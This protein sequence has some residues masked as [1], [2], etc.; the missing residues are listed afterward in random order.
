MKNEKIR[1]LALN[2]DLEAGSDGFYHLVP[3]GEFP[4]KTTAGKKVMQICDAQAVNRM[5][6]TFKPKALIDFEHRSYNKDGDT[7]AAGWIVEVAARPDGLWGKI[8]WSDLGQAA[9]ANKRYRGHSPVLDLDLLEGN[10]G[11]PSAIVGSGLT[12][13][14]VMRDALQPLLNKDSTGTT[15]GDEATAEE[16]RRRQMQNIAKALGLLETADEAAILAAIEKLKGDSAAG[17]TAANKVAEFEK[18]A[19]NSKVLKA[20]DD[21]KGKITAANKADIEA[22]LRKDYDGTVKVL[23]SIVV[24]AST[25]R[26][27]NRED[28]KTPTAAE[29]LALN[30]E[31]ERNTEIQKLVTVNRMSHAGAWSHLATSRPDLF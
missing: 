1:V 20:L 21:H 6:E 17:V 26:T 16:A 19:L 11:R 29:Q 2:R 10:R 30:K 13:M 12:N 8:D 5:V 27:L 14:G 25:T 4:T 9:V 22:A 7:S 24:T 3:L 18:E 31:T 15:P 23:N 28:G